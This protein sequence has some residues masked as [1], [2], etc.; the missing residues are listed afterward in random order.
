MPRNKIWAK[1]TDQMDL[2]LDS[3]GYYRKHTAKDGSCLYR[4]ISE[5]VLYSLE[6]LIILIYTPVE[7]MLHKITIKGTNRVLTFSKSI[8]C[9][10]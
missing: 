7:G 6:S 5:Q 4:A 2:W 9:L 1:P 3:Q 8:G 10:K